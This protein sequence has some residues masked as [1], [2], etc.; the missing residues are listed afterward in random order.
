MP[1]SP[2]VAYK[3]SELKIKELRAKA[4]QQQG[5]KF[6]VREF[7]DIVLQNGAVPLDVLEQVV[8]EWLASKK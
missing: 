1:P 6:D 7:H 5:D 8:N 2:A 3:I 4:K